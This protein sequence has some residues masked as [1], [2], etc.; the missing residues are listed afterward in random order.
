MAD[1]RFLGMR[2]TG[3]WVQDQRPKNWR[4]GILYLYPNGQA[5]LTAILSK[6]GSKKVDDPQFHWWTEVIDAATGTVTGVYTDSGLA[7]AYVS[8]GVAGDTLYVKCSEEDSKKVRA[9]HQVLLRDASD[10]T[11][12]VNAKVIASTQA[13]D[14]SYLTVK[15]LE[16][17][18]NSVTNDLSTADTFIVIGNINA[19]GASMPT[20]IARDPV[21]HY[22][23]TQIFRTPLEI[24]RTAMQTR[25]RT[26]DDYK[27]AKREALEMHSIEMELAFLFGIP[28]ENVGSNGK[29]ERTTGGLQYFIKSSAPSNVKDFTTD[30]AGQTWAAKGFDWIMESLEQIFRYGGQE[31]LALCGSGALLGIANAAMATGQMQLTPTTRAYGIKIVEWL[32]PWGTIYLKQH[33]LMGQIASL[34]NTILLLEPRNLMYRYITDTTFYSDKNGNNSGDRRI[35]GKVEEFLTEAGLEFHH[36]QTCG[37]LN[38]VGLNG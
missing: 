26:G 12:D 31:R 13:G 15:L 35:D 24:T 20:A 2:G 17:D 38:G 37:I 34:R 29:P 21:K 23:Y 6:L 33:P 28:T 22:N 27:K 16:D 3:D 8:G 4:E 32:T 14:N 5:P 25:L 9:G 19:E 10:L 30:Y 7:T 11:V 18:D 1:P 36:P